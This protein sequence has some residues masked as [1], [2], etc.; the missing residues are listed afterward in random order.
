M[1]MI[2]DVDPWSGEPQRVCEFQDIP[3]IEPD[4]GGH[5]WQTNDYR[6]TRFMFSSGDTGD[7]GGTPRPCEPSAEPIR[8]AKPATSD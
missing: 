7:P 5:A 1:P 6:R 2:E 8:S 4:R 3:I